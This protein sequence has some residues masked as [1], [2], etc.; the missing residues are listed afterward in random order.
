MYTI[1]INVNQTIIVIFTNAY[2]NY[3]LEISRP[4]VLLRDGNF[5]TLT[6]YNQNSPKLVVLKI[7]VLHY[8]NT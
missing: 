2:I 8:V 7:G 1:V 3:L 5:S 6:S 4:Q